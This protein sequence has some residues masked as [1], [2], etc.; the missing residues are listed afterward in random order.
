[1]TPDAEHKRPLLLRALTVRD[2]PVAAKVVGLCVSVTAVVAISLA[3]MGY[4]QAATGLE[5]QAEAAL[6]SD[7]L[8]V[9]NS[10]DDW[11]A[12]RLEE[13]RAVAGLPAVRRV[14]MSNGAAAPADVSS[15]QDAL[16]T[17]STTRPDVDSFSLIDRQGT[18][19]LSGTQD[20]LGLKVPQ[21]DYFQ[22]S[23]SGHPFITGVTVSLAT[24]ST[25]IIHSA[26]V[27]GDGGQ[28]EG[29]IRSRSSLAHVQHA[30]QEAA[31]RVGAGAVGVLLD[32]NG[33]VIAS[34]VDSS[35]LLRPVVPLRP[36]V[37]SS[38]IN[39]SQWGKG[40]APEAIGEPELARAVGI[41]ER[42]VFPWHTRGIQYHAVAVPVRQTHW[43]Y[44]AALPVNTFD[45]AARQFRRDAALAGLLGL[46]LAAVVAVLFSRPLARS[47][48]EAARAAQQIAEDD[49]PSFVRAA[50]ALAAG[51]LTR[52]P[53]IVAQRMATCSSDEVGTMVRS[54]NGMI[55]RLRETETAFAEMRVGLGELVGE[56]QGSAEGLA[57]TAQHLGRVADRNKVAIQHVTD[58]IQ[59]VAAGAR[60]TS[61]SA[62]ETNAAVGML[63]GAIGGIT[64]G[65]VGQS[66]Q[67]AQA[68][69]TVE[70]MAASV[71]RVAANTHSVSEAS[72][73]ARAAAE[74][75]AQAVERTV[76]EMSEIQTTVLEGARTVQQLGML[77]QKI[78]AVLE[79]I[80]ELSDQTN[81]LAL[82]AA[83]EAARAGEHGRGFAVVA[84]EIRKL[85][86]R[87]QR[88]TKQI[89]ELI[90]QVQSSTAHA[91][92][93]MEAGAA[94]VQQG[95]AQAT[96]AA[97]ALSEILRAAESTARQVTE[98]AASAGELELGANA[99][100]AAMQGIRTVAEENTATTE[101]M[102]AQ[103]EQVSGAMQ[104]IAAVSEEQTDAIHELAASADGMNDQMAT[105]RTRAH[106]LAATAERLTLLVAR[107]KVEAEVVAH[108][109]PPPIDLRL[110]A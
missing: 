16:T 70:Q 31:D 53:T 11:N 49:L 15:T 52:R 5:R 102:A 73:H 86:E 94:K 110:A 62:Q 9:A 88:E 26:P 63:S 25:I 54:F 65:A 92:T 6:G 23:M 60:D 108:V 79:T 89:A 27:L 56:V 84:D 103:A 61:R 48:K 10:I 32:Q 30:V 1:M 51:D 24:G 68:E 22:A 75:G 83:I 105:M 20:T 72:K 77:G 74:H 46:L 82:N 85:A 71:E 40:Q 45:A 3:T 12:E 35:W 90:V 38:L 64:H 97:G 7:A 42:V 80:D 29:V 17:F 107:F 36:D 14:V 21:R 18:Y 81:L 50:R 93:A 28:A 69:A 109:G 67:V 58:G 78:G 41:P 44:V 96:Q 47:L 59:V 13:L 39:G 55:D 2:W 87:S 98:I 91:V 106:E 57:S 104:G 95:S 101:E 34:T 43:T 99:V 19:F 37:Q 100:V 33:L 4:Q 8:L 76:S 66:Q